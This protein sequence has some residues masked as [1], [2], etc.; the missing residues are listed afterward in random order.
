MRQELKSRGVSDMLTKQWRPYTCA[1]LCRNCYWLPFK[2]NEAMGFSFVT[3]CV[4]LEPLSNTVVLMIED[5]Y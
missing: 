2:S 5:Q 4:I 1:I 3:M